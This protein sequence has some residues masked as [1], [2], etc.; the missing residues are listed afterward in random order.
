VEGLDGLLYGTTT[1]G[2]ANN[3]GTLF[4][5]GSDGSVA[6]LYSFAGGNDGITPTNGLSTISDGTIYGVTNMTVYGFN[7]PPAA[8]AAP[9]TNV[10]ATGA[11]LNG[12]ITGETYSGTVNFDYGL[13][14]SYGTS[15]PSVPFSTGFTANAITA[16]VTGLQPFETYH[17]RL[18]AVT[19]SG[20]F[21]S[22]DQT[23]ST[24]NVATFNSSADVPVNAN[25]FSATGLPLS[26]T[27]GFAPPPGTVLTLVNNTGFTPISGTFNGLPEGSLVSATFGAQTYSFAISYVGGAGN[28]ITLTLVTQAIT[29]PAIPNKQ[30]TDAPFTLGA[31]A[32][33]GLTVAYTIVAGS[34]SASVSGNTVTL[35][36]TAGSVT[37]MATQAGNGGAFGPAI[38]VYQTFAVRSG[39]VFTQLSSSTTA[40]F[41]IGIRADGTLWGW[42]LNGNGQ[43]GNG[44]TT[45]A[46]TPVQIGSINTW[47]SVSAGGGHAVAVRTD[48][49][50]WTW[51]LNSSGQLGD[52]T[53]TQ[54]TVPVQIAGTTW[55]VAVAANSHTVAVKSDG[56]LW[57]WGGNANGQLGQG[58]TDALTHTA[59]VQ[60]GALTTWAQTTN[61]LASGTDFTLALKADGTL[62]GWGLNSSG[63]VGDNTTT[64]RSAPVQIG[65]VTTWNGVFAGAAFSIGTR[66]DGTVWT[67]GSGTNGQLGNGGLLAV[68]FLSPTLLSTISN[69]Q[70]IRPGGSHVLATKT[71]GTLWAWGSNSPN[72]QLGLNTADTAIHSIPAQVGVAA[73]WQLL[74]PGATHSVATRSD[75]TVWAWGSNTNGQLGNLPRVPLPL[76]QQLGPVVSASSGSSHSVAIKPD[77]SMWVWGS[78]SNGQ[79]GLGATD[80]LPH[81]APIQLGAGSAWQIASAGSTH[82]LA[83]K[84]DGTLWACGSNGNGQLG[85]GTT[86]LRPSLFQIGTDN[87]WR[88]ISAGVSHSCAVKA[89]GTLWA[90]GNNGNG[91]LGDGT[92][93]QRYFPTQIG[94]DTNW[95]SVVTS[96]GGSF[97]VALKT[98]GTLWTWGLNSSGQLGDGTTTQRLSPAQIGTATWI[99]AASGVSHVVAI[100]SDGTLWAWG[101]NTNGRLGDGTST[102]RTSPVQIG[103]D[104]AWRSIAASSH[105]VAT[106]SDGSLWSWG[107]DSNG[108]LGD[109]NMDSGNHSTPTRV[110]TSNGWA[111]VALLA[112]SNNSL[113]VT[114]DGTLWGFGFATS[115]QIGFAWRN[116][117]VPDVTLPALSPAQTITFPTIGNVPVGNTVTLAATSSSGLPASYIV[118]GPATLNGSQL[119][120]TGPGPITVIAYQPGDSYWQSSDIAFQNVNLLPPTITGVLASGLTTNSIILNATVNPNGS[121]TSAKFQSGLTNAYG[122]DT[123]ITLT[124][125]NGVTG[126][127]VS[128]V[129]AG[130]I[131]GNTYHFRVS[132]TSPGG[133]TTTVDLTFNSVSPAYANWAAA[134]GISGPNSGPAADFD[135]DGLPNLLEWGFGTN[136]ASNGTG[137][138]AV[139]GSTITA[140]GVR[141]E[142][143]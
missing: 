66:S 137:P 20:S 58:T 46:R 45:T 59:P 53:T 9:A 133:T 56:T 112:N 100:R 80:A 89:D 97:T 86:I 118:S 96:G 81:P 110:G 72:G 54:R 90:W 65:A 114:S 134:N 13:T 139:N 75:G 7:P 82:T 95:K 63:Q 35:T 21:Y 28:D 30:T 8:F 22:Q 6:S 130:L 73:N 105:T 109:G 119:S 3:F 108:Q 17:Y 84:S 71:D 135:G 94:T 101:N 127:T 76:S 142:S 19:S 88:S 27:L 37:V 107:S 143:A 116:Q 62:W 18:T 43:L 111:S 128:A 125:N 32:S 121:V 117:L 1:S 141:S 23:F 41:T 25:G 124:P 79:L 4:R 24:P 140:Y 47:Q 5:V 83:L 91:Q 51:G 85:D 34:A 102:Q 103:T 99:A 113:A 115:G 93:V 131:P 74:A 14:T 120:V 10:L 11:T 69:V 106:K 77:G 138:L 15:A 126:Q 61:S 67:W 70:T 64:L 42:G 87:Q 129:I 48:G 31:T 60:I 68:S 136:P 36:G 104:N 2:G 33:S 50:L 12:S 55:R 39:A 132:A 16:S 123:P 122:T 98:D 49:T 29:F 38:P 40:D 52:G 78:N 26:I 57:S 92:T 44:T